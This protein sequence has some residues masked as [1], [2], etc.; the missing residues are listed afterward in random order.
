MQILR[1]LLAPQ[2]DSSYQVFRKLL[3]PAC[4]DLKVGATAIRF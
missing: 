1:R 4:A 3:S 2:D